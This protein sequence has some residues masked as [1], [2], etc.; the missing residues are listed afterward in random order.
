MC[1][2]QCKLSPCTLGLNVVLKL[3]THNVWTNFRKRAIELVIRENDYLTLLHWSRPQR[4][5]RPEFEKTV[6]A[7]TKSAADEPPE[8]TQA[9]IR[10]RTGRLRMAHTNRRPNTGAL[11]GTHGKFSHSFSIAHT[12][13]GA[14][15]TRSWFLKSCSNSSA[16]ITKSSV[17]PAGMSG[18]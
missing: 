17:T 10:L 18:R 8:T 14:R 5:L 6:F 4:I 1:T 15:D 12:R 3:S 11:R 2:W 7:L 13:K 9:L 16:S